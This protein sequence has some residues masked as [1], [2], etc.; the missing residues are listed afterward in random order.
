MYRFLLLLLAASVLLMVLGW[1]SVLPPRVE[2]VAWDVVSTVWWLAVPAVF[3]LYC[4]APGLFHRLDTTMGFVAG[5][6]GR[7]RRDAA[8]LLARIEQM[9]KPHHMAQL[10]HLYLAHGRPRKAA[11]WLERAL[12][13]DPQLLDARYH[14]A[15]CHLSR[16]RTPEAAELFEQVYA[17]KPDHDYGTLCLRLA[18]CHQRLGNDSR[19]SEIFQR[20][21]RF[22]PGHPEG[23]YHFALLEAK[24]GN[25]Q[26]AAQL[27]RDVT[28]AVRRSPRFHRR[29]N[30]HWAWKAR[31]WLWTKG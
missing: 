13:L 4:V 7:G 3:V 20:L 15:A 30:R 8:D 14:L 21:M 5:G 16:R 23:A 25:H 24:Q 11:H 19:A 22:Y 18:Q 27:M 29:R 12:E 17:T 2:A 9:G 6:F 31:W 26:R 28:I 10:G 1:A